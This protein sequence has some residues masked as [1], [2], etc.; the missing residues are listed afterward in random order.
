M[1]DIVTL[2]EVWRLHTHGEVVLDSFDT[3]GPADENTDCVHL[4]LLGHRRPA[5]FFASMELVLLDDTAGQI[6]EIVDALVTEPRDEC[7]ET[8]PSDLIV[9]SATF[10]PRSAR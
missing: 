4:W 1:S 7:F 3:L 2:S 6:F 5:G 10:P 8:R 9:A